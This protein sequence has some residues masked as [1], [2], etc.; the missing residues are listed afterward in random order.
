MQPMILSGYQRMSMLIGNDWNA[1]F[2]ICSS[3]VHQ[4][5]SEYM[6]MIDDVVTIL[7][8]EFGGSTHA[9]SGQKPWEAELVTCSQELQSASWLLGDV[10]QSGQTTFLKMAKTTIRLYAPILHHT[11][12][13][14]IILHHTTSYYIILH[15]TIHHTTSYYT[16]T[17]RYRIE[18]TVCFPLLPIALNI[19]TTLA[20]HRFAPGAFLSSDCTQCTEIAVDVS[21]GTPPSF[22]KPSC[23]N[24]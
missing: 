18:K 3:Y 5:M 4:N 14:Y 20:H 16:T 12:S 2:I 11:T 10:Q 8:R 1:M 6:M 15:H 9:D 21:I 22:T 13:Y 23:S 24:C 7:I 19:L 17:H